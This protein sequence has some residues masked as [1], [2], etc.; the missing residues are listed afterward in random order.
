MMYYMYQPLSEIENMDVSELRYKHGWLVKKKKE[1]YE[2][3]TGKKRHGK[4]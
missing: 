3:L 2:V 1:E 4:E